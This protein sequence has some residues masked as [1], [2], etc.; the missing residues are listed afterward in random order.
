MMALSF[1]LSFVEGAADVAVVRV[2][3]KTVTTSGQFFVEVVE[4]EIA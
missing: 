4:Q 3:A 2:A 1:A